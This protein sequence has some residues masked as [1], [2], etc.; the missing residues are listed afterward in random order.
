MDRPRRRAPFL[1][2]AAC[3]L[4]PGCLEG[5]SP[6]AAERPTRLY[7]EN[8]GLDDLVVRVTLNGA[9]PVTASLPHTGGAPNVRLAWEGNVT[10][11]EI[12]VEVEELNHGLR[13]TARFPAAAENHV[14]VNVYA[15]RTI[16]IWRLD[17]EPR[18]D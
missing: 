7:V 8:S 14:V 17:R 18:F 4:L 2:I 16:D 9:A 13:K 11:S 1:V 3:L 10:G 15:N 12:V 5:T 6:D